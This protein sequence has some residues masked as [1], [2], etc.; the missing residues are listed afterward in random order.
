MYTEKS[1]FKEPKFTN[2]DGWF[3]SFI[4]AVNKYKR[5]LTLDETAIY[6][7]FSL[8]YPLHNRT[9]FNE[10]KR[11]PWM[12][13]LRGQNVVLE[14]IPPH[15]FQFTNYLYIS[16]KLIQL[17]Q[18]ELKQAVEGKS[19]IY[20]LLSGGLDSRI[21]ALI[22]KKLIEEGEIMNPVTCMTWGMKDSLDVKYAK[23]IAEKLGFEWKWSDL[24]DQDILN[25][26]KIVC[27]DLGPLVSATL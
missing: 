11:L 24:N 2:G 20:L 4:N 18:N 1:L 15:S 25:N 13:S 22:L 27:D 19:K 23:L 3:N 14:A 26:I 9:I 12:S 7:L 16:M 5:E 10:I 17:L 8:G 21:T 6:S